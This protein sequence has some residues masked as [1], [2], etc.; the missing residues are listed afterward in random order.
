MSGANDC[1]RRWGCRFLRGQGRAWWARVGPHLRMANGSSSSPPAT[2]FL[3]LVDHAANMH[4]HVAEPRSQ[5]AQHKYDVVLFGDTVFDEYLAAIKAKIGAIAKEKAWMTENEG[6]KQKELEDMD[7][8]LD[9]L[10]AFFI[11]DSARWAASSGPSCPCPA[12]RQRG[13]RLQRGL[14]HNRRQSIKGQRISNDFSMKM[15]DIMPKYT[16]SADGLLLLNHVL[17]D[18]ALRHAMGC[19]LWRRAR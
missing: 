3:P 18:E 1:R 13:A 6:W 12:H 4:F 2:S 15:L 5:T 7:C 11:D 8:A 10:H 9:E 19:W 17:P 14:G 16:Q